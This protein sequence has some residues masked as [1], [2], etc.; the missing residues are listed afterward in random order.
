MGRARCPISWEVPHARARA[1]ERSVP[2]FVAERILRAGMVTDVELPAGGP[3]RWRVI[4][5]DPDGRPVA[6]VVAVINQSSL[7]VI[8]VIR[9]DE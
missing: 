4:G 5:R 7:R 3:E 9:T 2:I 6:V 8:T 1:R